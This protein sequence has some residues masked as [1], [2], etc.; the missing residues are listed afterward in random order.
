MKQPITM[1]NA[2]TAMM[3]TQIIS[4][5]SVLVVPLLVAELSRLLPY[6]NGRPQNG[7]VG[8]GGGDGGGPDGGGEGMSVVR[9]MMA[10]A[11]CIVTL[12]PRVVASDV[13]KLAERVVVTISLGVTVHE[14]AS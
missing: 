3:I 1:T 12:L 2:I 10:G 11:E 8:G 13:M 7:V 5:V 9:I 6:P 14:G 4:L